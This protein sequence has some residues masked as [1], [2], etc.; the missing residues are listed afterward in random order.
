L[1]NLLA[2][3]EPTLRIVS[4][5]VLREAYIFSHDLER[6]WTNRCNLIVAELD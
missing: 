5:V 3:V 4:T 2:F 1:E 6:G